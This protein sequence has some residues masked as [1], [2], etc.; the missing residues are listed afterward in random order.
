MRH[1]HQDGAEEGGG[2]DLEDPGG[3]AL[4]VTEGREVEDLVRSQLSDGEADWL[5]ST[6]W[7]DDDS[8]SRPP[9]ARHG[10][11]ASIHQETDEEVRLD[12]F[13]LSG[14]RTGGPHTGTL[15]C[16]SLQCFTL[17][18]LSLLLL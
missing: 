10:T 14:V 8:H 7:R 9:T 17:Q 18:L 6:L 2:G 4:P 15:S 5:L 1:L 3:Q 16:C 11:T 13:V 12:W